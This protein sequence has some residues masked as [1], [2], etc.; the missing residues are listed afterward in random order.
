LHE[1]NVSDTQLSDLNGKTLGMVKGYIYDSKLRK[2]YPDINIKYYPNMNEALISV[3]NKKID[4][5]MGPLFLLFALTKEL[6]LNNLKIMGDSE[7]Q[8]ELRIGIQKDNQVLTSI[9]SKAVLSLTDKDNAQIRK[10]WAEK[11]KNSSKKLN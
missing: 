2:Q 5:T 6:N 3:S 1:K 10:R 11:R 4:A 9:L 7:Y 8:D